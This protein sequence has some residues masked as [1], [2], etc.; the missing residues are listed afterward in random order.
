MRRR[1][2]GLDPGRNRATAALP[3][4]ARQADSVAERIVQ[5]SG[6]WC[7]GVRIA[8]LKVRLVAKNAAAATGRYAARLSATRTVQ[9]PCRRSWPRPGGCWRIC[10]DSMPSCASI[11]S[12]RARARSACARCRTL[13][14]FIEPWDD[15]AEWLQVFPPLAQVMREEQWPAGRSWHRRA[16][17]WFTAE[18]DWQ[19]AF[20]QALLAEEYE[21]AVSLLQ[22]FSFEHLFRAAERGVAAAPA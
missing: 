1:D 2:A 9:Q 3:S 15:S 11:C 17:Q 16:C 7:A 10:R 12:A 21:V 18:Q 6:G 14:C 5:R 20:E 19:A 13:G 8:L 4:D 22:H